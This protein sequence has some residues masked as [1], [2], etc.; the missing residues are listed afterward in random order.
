M[1]FDEVVTEIPINRLD[2]GRFI[3]FFLVGR[4]K[5][6]NITIFKQGLADTNLVRKKSKRSSRGERK[7]RINGP[8]PD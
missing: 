2:L 1:L 4:S 3:S 6:G 7:I 8:R 5:I